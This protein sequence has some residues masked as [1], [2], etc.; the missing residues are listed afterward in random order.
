MKKMI[1]P[2]LL[3]SAFLFFAFGAAAQPFDFDVEVVNGKAAV[4][5]EALVK[6]RPGASAALSRL[7]SAADASEAELIGAGNSGRVKA[8]TMNI[9]ALM[10][11]LGRDPDV[12]LVEPNYIVQASADA[13]D[14]YYNLL[15]G[16]KNTG[17]TIGGQLGV[18]GADIEAT[19]AWDFTKGSTA[20]VVGIVDTGVNYSHPDLAANMWKAPKQFTVNIGG[21][22]VTCA[23]GT[24][25]FNAISKT[26]DPN[27]DNDH[28]SHVAGTIGAVGNNGTGVTGV[29][30]TASMMGL[31]FLS[32]SGSGSTSDAI[33][34]IE[35]AIQAKQQNVANVRVL[36]NSWGGGGYS[37][38]LKEKIEHANANGILF[39]ASAGNSGANNDIT[40]SYPASYDVPNVISVAATDNRDQLASFSNYGA[41]SVDLGAPG[42]N[43]ASTSKTGYLYMSG[44]S[45]AAPHVSGVAALVLAK[46]SLDTAALRANL[47]GSVES[48]GALLGKT[49][50]GGRLNAYN[51]LNTCGGTPPPPAKDFS[52]SATPATLSTTQGGTAQTTVSVSTTGWDGASIALS[53]AG[54]PSGAS[55]SFSPDSLNGNGSSGVTI[56]TA[57]ST[58]AGTYTV[59]I[60]GVSGGTT[61]TT[62]VSLTVTAPQTPD[63]G[64]SVSPATVVVKRGA[65]AN[66]TVTVTA[67]GGFSG[68]VALGVTGLPAGSTASFSPASIDGGGTSTLRVTTTNQTP[69]GTF[70]LTITGTSGSVAKSVTTTLKTN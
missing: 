34:A 48:I 69:K 15:W 16:L 19:K 27:D 32:R 55:A 41:N 68:S 62:S 60:S 25:G 36:N 37:A 31:K 13:N 52:L 5:K 47:L 49:T 66:Y 29:N 63:F 59:V 40:P 18:S 30:W 54:L 20:N 44:T 46:C 57:S 70:T 53:A 58:P 1:G 12:E 11:L 45:M 3:L 2:L 42:V 61:K 21:T 24:S 33:N 65:A 22:L 6:F 64:I 14:T 4:A 56:S 17:Q 28:G 8:R 23:V 7:A 38:L 67:T 9:V 50:T 35:F 43:I 51:A 39:V 26:C 10:Q